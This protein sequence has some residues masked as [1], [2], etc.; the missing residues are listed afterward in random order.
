MPFSL[1]S[2]TSCLV[3]LQFPNPA[4]VQVHWLILGAVSRVCTAEGVA[5]A[6]AS[7]AVVQLP[8]L[9]LQA[10]A[11]VLD[12]VQ[13][14]KMDAVLRLGASFREFHGLHQMSL[15]P[16]ALR[17]GV[18]RIANPRCAARLTSTLVSCHLLHCLQHQVCMRA[19]VSPALCVCHVSR[20]FED[21]AAVI[22]P[23]TRC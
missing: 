20:Q 2:V 9:V 19:V 23:T 10:L 13:P 16:N 12:Y 6:A 18:T 17:Y 4:P 7:K 21:A 15:S 5:E 3:S 8:P 1:H 14:L 22:S 11:H